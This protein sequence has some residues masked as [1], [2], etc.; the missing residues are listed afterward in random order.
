M[1]ARWDRSRVQDVSNGSNEG[2]PKG[3]EGKW[4]MG[5]R[6]GG[7]TNIRSNSIYKIAKLY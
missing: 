7:D 1:V 4:S 6:N 5:W 2:G 3:G